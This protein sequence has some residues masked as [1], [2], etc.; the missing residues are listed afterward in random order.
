[1]AGLAFGVGW[2]YPAMAWMWF[3]TVPGYLVV[4]LLF[5]SLHAGAAALAPIGAGA[6]IAR[7]AAHTLAEMVRL[8]FPFG[9]VPLATLG[10]AQS[11]GP[12]LVVA[13]V[14][15]VIALTWLLMPSLTRLF[16]GWL[17]R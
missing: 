13:R 10:I 8:V 3:L 5:A 16:A 17:R 7:P 1:M 6:T 4:A 15:G 14:G 2:M 12:L 9:G 11:G